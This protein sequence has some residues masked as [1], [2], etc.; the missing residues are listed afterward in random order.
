V[1][2]DEEME[3]TVACWVSARLLLM[4]MCQCVYTFTFISPR[5]VIS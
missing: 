5:I 3:K 2:S 4:C 1:L